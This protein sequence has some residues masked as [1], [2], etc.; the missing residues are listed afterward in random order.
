MNAISTIRAKEAL[1]APRRK[2]ACFCVLFWETSK[3]ICC[4]QHG[5]RSRE[6]RGA[7]ASAIV[8][9]DTHQTSPHSGA[10]SPQ[11]DGAH[12]S[13]AEWTGAADETRRLSTHCHR[14]AVAGQIMSSREQRPPLIL[15]GLARLTRVDDAHRLIVVIVA[16]L[17]QCRQV[18]VAVVAGRVV[19]MRDGEDDEDCAHG[20]PRGQTTQSGQERVPGGHSRFRPGL[21][22]RSDSCAR[23]RDN[24][25]PRRFRASAPFEDVAARAG[26]AWCRAGENARAA[27]KSTST[28]KDTKAKGFTPCSVRRPFLKSGIVPRRPDAELLCRFQQTGMP[29]PVSTAGTRKTRYSR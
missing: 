11:N 28:L 5:S 16:S 4:F 22:A 12:C 8:V 15:P 13:F 2:T 21:S 1:P 25:L 6:G 23:A 10:G 3:K 17:A 29:E 9:V 7:G 14:S 20:Q 19:E 26:A 27:A 18:L 24:L